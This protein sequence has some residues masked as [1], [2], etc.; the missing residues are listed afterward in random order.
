[1][2]YSWPLITTGEGENEPTIK[3]YLL[4]VYGVS[5]GDGPRLRAWN[6]IHTYIHT[7]MRYLLLQVKLRSAYADVDLHTNTKEVYLKMYKNVKL[8]NNNNP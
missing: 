3:E 7:Y 6:D 1:M 4:C 2:R 8:F 5:I